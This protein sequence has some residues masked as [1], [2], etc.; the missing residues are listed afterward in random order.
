[1]LINHKLSMARRGML[2][3]FVSDLHQYNP[4]KKKK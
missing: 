1:M 2:S 4:Q 3:K